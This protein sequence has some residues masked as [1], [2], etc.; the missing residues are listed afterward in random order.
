MIVTPVLFV[1]TSNIVI[2]T[3]FGSL[4]V[5]LIFSQI[6]DHIK[7]LDHV[8]RYINTFTYPLLIVFVYYVIIQLLKAVEIS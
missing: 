5:L 7:S 2:F 3:V 8:V 1:D 4:V 6:M